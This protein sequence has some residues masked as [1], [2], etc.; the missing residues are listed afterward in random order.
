MVCPI[1]AAE[2]WKSLQ[3]TWWPPLLFPFL[4]SPVVSFV[5]DVFNCT[6]V[7]VPLKLVLFENCFT[8]L[9]GVFF[10]FHGLVLDQDIDSPVIGPSR[11][12][13]IHNLKHIYSTRTNCLHQWWLRWV[14]IKGV[15][16]SHL[17]SVLYFL[18]FNL[19]FAA[20]CTSEFFFVRAARTYIQSTMDKLA[21]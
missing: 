1:S 14:T 15:N 10:C 12:R 5:N 7:D 16:I 2:R 3:V 4:Q 11:Y 6:P 19:F 13:Y 21:N 20:L 9:L 17:L 18:I 8:E